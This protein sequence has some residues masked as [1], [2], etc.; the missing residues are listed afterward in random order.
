MLRSAALRTT[1]TTHGAELLIGSTPS[2]RTWHT[3][4]SQHTNHIAE[5][6][7]FVEALHFLL[8]K[9]L[10]PR[11]ARACIFFD[12]RYA[13]DVCLGSILPRCNV[14]P[15]CSG[16]SL[17]LEAQ[18]RVSSILRH[19]VSHVGNTRDE[20]AHHAAA[21]GTLG[22]TSNHNSISRCP[23]PRHNAT[24][25]MDEDAKQKMLTL[26]T[27]STVSGTSDMTTH[28]RSRPM[29]L[30]S[31]MAYDL[32]IDP[33]WFS[34]A[35]EM[36]HNLLAR[37]LVSPVYGPNL[38]VRSRCPDLVRSRV[39]LCARFLIATLH[40]GLT[41]MS[42]TSGLASWT[43]A[44]TIVSDL[45]FKITSHVVLGADGRFLVISPTTSCAPRFDEKHRPQNVVCE[46]FH[47]SVPV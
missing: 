11:E 40:L 6:S 5:L 17:L 36:C 22:L 42:T 1:L 23:P 13:A 20:C 3:L 9:G 21:F 31:V 19:I 45:C 8:P 32:S 16:Q 28:I 37:T 2:R 34:A 18:L 41:K 26:Q 35:A 38:G 14:R 29:P 15:A 25:L 44:S 24:S 10:V 27:L 47:R 33:L 7:G 43:S 30:V 39:A 46:G 4:A 12:S